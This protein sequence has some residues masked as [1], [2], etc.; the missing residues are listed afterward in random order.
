MSGVSG[1]PPN[2][3]PSTPPLWR[4]DDRWLM[5]I[6]LLPH[7]DLEL[8]QHVTNVLG[9]MLAYARQTQA[10]MLA[11]PDD[12]ESDRYYLLFS[13]DAPT[14][15][16]DFLT[17]LQ[18]NA[19]TAQPSNKILVPTLAEINRAELIGSVLPQDIL[20]NVFYIAD[21]LFRIAGSGSTIQ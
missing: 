18:L 10:C 12:K 6:E 5:L 19:D 2:S 13:F 9:H 3:G 15:K 7:D 21:T 14:D 1:V 11:F 17:L 16:A 8:R 4:D 20:F